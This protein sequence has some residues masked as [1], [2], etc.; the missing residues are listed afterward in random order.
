MLEPPT[1]PEPVI[2]MAVEPKTK[3]DREKMG[4]GYSGW[5]RRPHFRCF[6][7]E[8]DGAAHIARAWASLHLE[9]IRDRPVPEFKV[10]APTP[11]RRRLLTGDG[12]QGR[13]GRREVHPAVGGAGGSMA[14][15]ASRWRRMRAGRAWRLRT[16]SWA[17]DSQGVHPACD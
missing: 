6:T 10:G 3:A 15:R 17:G 4:Q 11:A 9:I 12:D 2:S 14:T 13:R 8:G 16:R 1:F 5:H 7:N